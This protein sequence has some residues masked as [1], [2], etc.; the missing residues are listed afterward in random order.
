MTPME[1]VE[2]GRSIQDIGDGAFI[3][4]YENEA[5]RRKEIFCL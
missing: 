1:F 5:T 3:S 2:D 4:L